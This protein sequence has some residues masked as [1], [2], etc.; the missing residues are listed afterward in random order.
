[1]ASE[2]IKQLLIFFYFYLVMISY[3]C[4]I[5]TSLVIIKMSNKYIFQ[6]L[7]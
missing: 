7:L 5:S 2:E 1:M 6:N 4:N 3:D